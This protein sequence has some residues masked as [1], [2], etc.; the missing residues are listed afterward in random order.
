MMMCVY[1]CVCLIFF[2]FFFLFTYKLILNGVFYRLN[3]N[4]C[5][6]VF[7]YTHLNILK[8]PIT[9]Y[10]VYELVINKIIY[11][12]CVGRRLSVRFK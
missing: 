7:R 3:L 9:M 1:V 6:I 2:F 5:V 8:Y 12:L 11:L 10:Y 4:R